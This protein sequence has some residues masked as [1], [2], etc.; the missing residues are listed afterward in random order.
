MEY[1]FNQINLAKN[2]PLIFCKPDYKLCYLKNT[3]GL[4]FLIRHDNAEW[5]FPSGKRLTIQVVC[6][7]DY[8]VGESGIK[9]CQRKKH[10]ITVGRFYQKILAHVF[11]A[12]FFSDSH[13]G[14]FQDFKN[15]NARVVA[16]F[17]S[18]PVMTALAR[19][20]FAR[21]LP[22]SVSG[23]VTPPSTLMKDCSMVVCARENYML[24]ALE[25]FT[26]VRESRVYILY[27]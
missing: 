4:F 1:F 21:S 9:L 19:F 11:F 16:C 17:P 10:F 20:I 22:F 13:A 2:D 27:R 14:S 12:Q 7:D 15:R 26:R 24:R 23:A 5:P 3:P 6:Q 25:G 18:W 8:P